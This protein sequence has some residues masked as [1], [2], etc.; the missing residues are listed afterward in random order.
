MLEVTV[1]GMMMVIFGAL[2]CVE[3]KMMGKEMS[4]AFKEIQGVLNYQVDCLLKVEDRCDKVGNKASM[5]E[6]RLE[7]LVGSEDDISRHLHQAIRGFDKELGDE[8]IM[9]GWVIR[10]KYLWRQARLRWREDS[11]EAAWRVLVK[12]M[13]KN[14]KA[15]LDYE[16]EIHQACLKDMPEELKEEATKATKQGR[17]ALEMFEAMWQKGAFED[18]AA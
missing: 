10:E 14:V 11:T 9:K 5:I 3:A 18:E 7:G 1:A 6:R 4:K 17:E 13:V 16:E 2:V 15:E 12:G 8:D